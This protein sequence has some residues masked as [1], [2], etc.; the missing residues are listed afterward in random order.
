MGSVLSKLEGPVH[1]GMPSFVGLA[2][3]MGHMPWADPG[4]PGFL[5]VAHAPFRP[6]GDWK[7]DDKTA[8]ASL[9]SVP[10]RKVFMRKVQNSWF[11]ENKQK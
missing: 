9:K 10:E 6:E 3:K 7:A 4:P 2:P 5:G 1:P 8:S 11:L